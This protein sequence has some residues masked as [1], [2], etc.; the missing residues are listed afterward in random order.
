LALVVQELARRGWVNKRW[1]TR[2]GRV[3]GGRL[4]TKSTLHKL[5]TNVTYVAKVCYKG[6]LHAGEQAAV[7]DEALWQEVQERLHHHARTKGAMARNR[8]GALLKGLRFG[9][10]KK[11]SLSDDPMQPVPLSSQEG[12]ATA[13]GLWQSVKIR[14]NPFARQF[15]ENLL[16]PQ[17]RHETAPFRLTLSTLTDPTPHWYRFLYGGRT[18][19]IIVGR[20]VIVYFVDGERG[21]DDLSANGVIR[22][23]GA[24][25]FDSN[26]PSTT[27]ALDSSA[28]STV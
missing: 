24:P 4:F 23:P 14:V 21:D 11:S 25:A 17:T 26:M 18:G 5:L 15:R 27:I 8:Y 19:A 12:P 1:V 22:D 3:W 28:S 2:K 10:V 6:E 13:G 7:V 9:A 20:T 16:P